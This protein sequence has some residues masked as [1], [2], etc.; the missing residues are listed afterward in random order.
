MKALAYGKNSYLTKGN[1]IIGKNLEKNKQ[2]VG[3][4]APSQG[5][6][7]PKL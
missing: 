5:S 1:R 6:C 7:I 3:A 2:K 4:N